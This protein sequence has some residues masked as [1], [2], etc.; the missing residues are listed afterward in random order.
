MLLTGLL[1]LAISIALRNLLIRPVTHLTEAAADISRGNLDV[2]LEA[3]SND[4]IGQLTSAFERMRLS[5]KVAMDNM[6][7]R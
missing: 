6:T 2:S 4:E 7:A 1:A 3:K 5:L